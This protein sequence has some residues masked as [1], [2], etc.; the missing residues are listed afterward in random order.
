MND[1]LPITLQTNVASLSGT[2]FLYLLVY[3]GLKASDKILA[4]MPF[5]PEEIVLKIEKEYFQRKKIY[6]KSRLTKYNYQDYLSNYS[7]KDEKISQNSHYTL[8][9]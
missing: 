4:A 2:G 3:H 6:P 1:Y 7:F 5:K 8:N 9:N